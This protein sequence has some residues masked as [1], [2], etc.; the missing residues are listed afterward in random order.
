M[1][2]E[3]NR[4]FIIPCTAE[5]IQLAQQQQYNNGPQMENHVKAFAEDPTLLNWGTWLVMLKSSG[6]IIGDIGF[7]GK[8]D[9]QK[10]VEIGYGFLE[11]YWH[12]GYATEAVTPLI[13][14]AWATGAVEA[15]KA[16]TELGNHG[17]VRVLEKMNMQKIAE[18]ES[19][20]YWK[21]EKPVHFDKLTFPVKG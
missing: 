12:K 15:I 18:S 13:E 8:P 10:A 21:L 14:W 17:S 16:D 20:L 3:T 1:K 19:L 11:E 6:K 7:K 9:E 2:L 5:S 4:L